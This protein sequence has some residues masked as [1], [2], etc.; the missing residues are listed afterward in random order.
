MAHYEL[1]EP[2]KASYLHLLVV[3]FTQDISKHTMRLRVSNCNRLCKQH[4]LVHPGGLMCR[5]DY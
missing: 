4:H 5:H 1:L 2:I 3:V